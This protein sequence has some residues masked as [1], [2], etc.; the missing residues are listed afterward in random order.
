MIDPSST[1]QPALLIANW[2][3]TSYQLAGILIFYP[4]YIQFEILISNIWMFKPTITCGSWRLGICSNSWIIN[5]MTWTY[6]TI[7]VQKHLYR[8]V[9]FYKQFTF[10]PRRLITIQS[11]CLS[12][13]SNNF[14]NNYFYYWFLIT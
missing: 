9:I 5:T 8:Q 2:C 11:I 12:T 4:C 13:F 1:P 6:T 7:H 3:S 10:F 14:Y